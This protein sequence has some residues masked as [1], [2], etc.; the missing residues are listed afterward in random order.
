MANSYFEFKRFT[1]R[2]EGAA[3]KVGTDGVLLGACADIS[4]VESILDIGT[5]TGLIAIMCAQRSEAKIIAIEPDHNSYLQAFENV[6]AC[7]WTDRISV[8]ESDLKDF[9]SGNEKKF[10]IIISNPPYFRNSL[11][12]P[13]ESKAS[14]RHTF[15]LSSDDLIKCTNDLLK[16]DGSLQLILPY[17]EGNLFIAEAGADGL[18]CNAIIKV[19]PFPEGKIIRLIMKFERLKKTTREKYLTIE[20]GS[21]HNYTEEYKGLTNDFYL[22]F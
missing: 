3:F 7:S 8:I 11:L 19:K 17:E 13:D 12:N 21:R 9:S 5:G 2:Q 15:S 6:N 1:I 18:Y 14:A 10:D 16:P 4:G 22:K 20:T